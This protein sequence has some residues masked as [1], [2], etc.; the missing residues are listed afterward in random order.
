MQETLQY[1]INLIFGIP[2]LRVKLYTMCSDR[3]AQTISLIEGADYSG[4]EPSQHSSVL[5]HPLLL[6]VKRECIDYCKQYIT[7]LSHVADGVVITNS[8]SNCMYDGKDIDL[9]VH[10]NS[11][12]NGSIYLS[13]GTPITFVNDQELF[14]IEPESKVSNT[15]QLDMSPGELLLFPSKVKHGVLQQDGAPPRYSIAFNTFPT[16]RYDGTNSVDNFIYDPYFL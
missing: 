13:K 9:H 11:Y 1:N 10:R 2:I 3:I 8:W 4:R 14:F 12:I 7:S 5:D 15:L 16:R 6:D